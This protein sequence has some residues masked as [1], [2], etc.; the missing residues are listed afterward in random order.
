M[1][2]VIR[3]PKQFVC[4]ECNEIV[5]RPTNHNGFLRCDHAHRVQGLAKSTLAEAVTSSFV[6]LC[7][8]GFLIGDGNAISGKAIGS[9]VAV[10]LLFLGWAIFLLSRGMKYRAIPAPTRLLV[11]Q[12]TASGAAFLVFGGLILAGVGAGPFHWR[13]HLRSSPWTLSGFPDK[14]P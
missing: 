3:T 10:S 11:K 6:A 7:L 8:S 4:A 1:M 2:P 14:C 9:V 12:Y 5:T 13:K